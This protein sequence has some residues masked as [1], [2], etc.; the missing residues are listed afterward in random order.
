M[1]SLPAIIVALTLAVTDASA[2][3]GSSTGGKRTGTA[4]AGA[5]LLTLDSIFGSDEFNDR[6]LG[7]FRW[8][9]RTPSYF[10]LDTPQAGGKGRD[11]VRNDLAT[12][13]KEV[14]VPASVFIPPG[15]SA[16]LDVQ[17]FEFSADESKL[18]L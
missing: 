12:G 17:G 13:R 3:E 4:A 15:Q 7:Q 16:P 1:K 9:K 5:A 10:T 2:S 11:L 8:S 14:V 18:L 6:G